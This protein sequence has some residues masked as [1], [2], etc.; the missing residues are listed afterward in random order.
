MQIPDFSKFSKNNNEPDL[1]SNNI[2]KEIRIKNVNKLIIGNLN[3]NSIRNKFEDLKVFIDKTFDILII[4]ETKIDASFPENQFMIEG[5]CKPYRLDRNKYGGG[6]LMYVREDIPSKILIEYKQP[7]DIEGIFVEINLRKVKWLLFGSYHPPNQDDVYYFNQVSKAQDFCNKKYEKFLLTGDFNAEDTERTLSEFLYKFNTKNIVKDKT[8]FKNPNN[9]SCIDLFLTNSPDS[10]H[11]TQAISTGLSDVHKLVMTVMKT[12]FKTQ[13][14]KQIYYRDYKKFDNYNFKKEL[15]ESLQNNVNNYETFE[16]IFLDKL[17]KYAPL[18]QKITRA[19]HAPYMNKYLRKCIM[20]RSELEN[21]YYK[22]KTNEN[23]KAY[24]KHKNFCSKLYKKERKKFYTKLNTK[25]VTDN[26]LFW[27]TVKPFLSDKTPTNSNITLINGDEIVSEDKTVSEKLNNFFNNAVDD[28]GIT[29]SNFVNYTNGILDPV[30]R[31]IKKFEDHPSIKTIENSL[32]HI[33]KFE[34]SEISM[35]E[36][37]YEINSLNV[38]KSGTFKNIPTKILKETSDIS[39]TTLLKIWNE[40]IVPQQKFPDKL[41]LADV[42]PIFKKGD[43]NN[44]KLD[45]LAKNYRPVSVLPSVSK[46]FER[47][48]QKQILTYIDKF[49]SPSMCGFRKGFNTQTA[50]LSL[51][52]KWKLVLDKKGYA[53]ALLMDLSKAFDTINHELLI[54]KL[55][56]Y[57]FSMNALKLVLDYLSN[58]WQRVKI[59][60][61]FS[62]WSELLK[63]VPQGSVLGPLLFNL[64]LNDLFFNLTCDACNFADDTTPFVSS[65][66]LDEVLEK[67]EQNVE[68][69]LN[70]FNENYM[71][72][73]PEKSHLLIAG[74]K[75]NKEIIRV[76]NDTISETHDAK[77]LGVNIDS[78]LK[79]DA[80]IENTCKKAN[81]KLTALSRMSKFMDFNQK[82]IL[83]KAFFDSQFK[84]CPLVWMFHSRKANHKINKLHERALRLIYN[85]YISTFDTLLD[86]D[87]SFTVHDCNLQVLAIEMY[88]IYNNISTVNY[89]ELFVK[90]DNNFSLRFSS[91]FLIPQVNSVHKGQQSLRYLGPIIWNLIPDGIKY[92]SSLNAFKNNIKKWKPQNCPCRLCKEYIPGV[93][94]LD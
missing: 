86:K 18:K 68:I 44:I 30:E 36:L 61:T 78:T 76:G 43:P 13:K 24:K 91:D 5:Y 49:L 55:N 46:I 50:L 42:T 88:K 94:F 89:N 14:G 22:N 84:Y 23:L 37:E 27:R 47:I 41:K 79:F 59:N 7:N 82:R 64:Y 3:I 72:M 35:T 29:E 20:K 48:M 69:C 57:G 71:K 81:S 67:L 87:N 40:E 1:I 10:F 17:E 93:G 51:I 45:S 62:S 74:N 80:H 53:G 90:K 75:E 77:L 19:N 33:N 16:H 31:A 56:A 12:S 21:K 54:A 34:F 25:N 4:T 83:F 73:N 2:L 66:N 85:D 6:V 28:L 32:F 39:S 60:T 92:I 38:N 11:S 15:R 63:G 26:K 70:W 58:R 9:P 52:E 8:C 65:M